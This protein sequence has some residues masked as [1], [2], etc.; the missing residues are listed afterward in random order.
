M[1]ANAAKDTTALTGR[2]RQRTCAA[3]S[4]LSE[5]LRRQAARLAGRDSVSTVDPEA[6]LAK[7]DRLDVFA[8]NLRQGAGLWLTYEQALQAWETAATG[9]PTA[10]PL[11]GEDCAMASAGL[12]IVLGMLKG[13]SDE[14]VDKGLVALRIRELDGI[15]SLLQQAGN[16]QVGIARCL[17]QLQE[18]AAELEVEHA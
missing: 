18:A 1:V 14:N 9:E 17:D 8:A 11:A 13:G 7:A 4:L 3:L 16:C 2:Q 10:P 6:A 15:A 12:R 5:H